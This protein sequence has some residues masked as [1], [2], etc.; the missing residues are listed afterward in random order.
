MTGAG[1]CGH[2]Q[3]EGTKELTWTIVQRFWPGMSD[4][5]VWL[6]RCATKSEGKKENGGRSEALWCREPQKRL[7]ADASA[8]R[9]TATRVAK[10]G[11]SWIEDA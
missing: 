1:D 10:L 2:V 6:E 3:S 11:G 9:P 8:G 5:G 7:G 4:G